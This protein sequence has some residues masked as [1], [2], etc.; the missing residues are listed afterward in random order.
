MRKVLFGLALP[1]LVAIIF[2]QFSNTTQQAAGNQVGN[3][4]LEA[5]DLKN[6]D[7]GLSRTKTQIWRTEDGADSWLEI[8]PP[9][10][11]E[12][13]ISAASFS[14]ARRGTAILANTASS[15]LELAQTADGGASWSKQV[16]NLSAEIVGEADLTKIQL[17]FAD[18]QNGFL[19]LRLPSSSNFTRAAIFST[20][21]SGNSWQLKQSFMESG[22][23]PLDSLLPEKHNTIAEINGIDIEF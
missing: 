20:N 9:K 21:D 18:H 23:I 11:D 17:E 12:Q 10:T 19:I 7:F 3:E 2:L 14:D 13:I 4:K 1:L 5:F 15:S 16:L 22:E 6:D 8:T